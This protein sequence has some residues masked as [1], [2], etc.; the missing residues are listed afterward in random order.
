MNQHNLLVLFQ[1]QSRLI[2]SISFL[3]YTVIMIVFF[4]KDAYFYYSGS[5]LF[6]DGQFMFHFNNVITRL[7]CGYLGT[8][9]AIS[10][11]W[12]V[13]SGCRNNKFINIIATIGKKSLGIYCFQTIICEY[14]PRYLPYQY[15]DTITI[16]I[17][18]LLLLIIS[19]AMT[20]FA[21]KNNILKKTLLGGR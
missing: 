19:L 6:K 4:N 20:S 11:L 5:H 18:F 3:V 15:P 13:Y 1:K 10:F 12:I 14:L 16:T 21:E 17:T 8:A 7:L 9:T 2:A